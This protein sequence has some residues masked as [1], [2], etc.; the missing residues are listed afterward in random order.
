MADGIDNLDQKHYS[1]SKNCNLEERSTIKLTDLNQ[2]C[3]E[4]IFAYLDLESLLNVADAN[5]E[6]K[7][8]TYM[9]F[10][11][12]FGGKSVHIGCQLRDNGHFLNEKVVLRTFSHQQTHPFLRKDIT[13]V[14]D[15]FS[16]VTMFWRTYS[17]F[18]LWLLYFSTGNVS[19]PL[20]QSLK[21]LTLRNML[22]LDI[23]YDLGKIFSNVEYL[24]FCDSTPKITHKKNFV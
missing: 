24:E 10:V 15:F 12:N 3:L 11:Q 16:N 17:W 18:K 23:F 6:L 4:H 19:I 1:A 7:I 13:I 20:S 21:K 9:P 2:F 8:A 22:C 5:K 14:E